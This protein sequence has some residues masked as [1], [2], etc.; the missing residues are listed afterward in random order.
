MADTAAVQFIVAG[1]DEVVNN[2]NN[3]QAAAAAVKGPK[4]VRVLA[5]AKHALTAAQ[6]TEAANAAAEWL[7]GSSRPRKER[8]RRFPSGP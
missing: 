4:E 6:R 8:A 2:A 5:G 7:S 3:A 1:A